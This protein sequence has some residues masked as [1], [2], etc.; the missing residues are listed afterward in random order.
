[1]FTLSLI[2]F[3][4]SIIIYTHIVPAESLSKPEIIL[5]HCILKTGINSVTLTV[6][7]SEG[8]WQP[9]GGVGA[10]GLRSESAVNKRNNIGESQR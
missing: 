6:D 7:T 10:G 2:W 3:Y 1:M 8:Q 4:L 5:L 9:N